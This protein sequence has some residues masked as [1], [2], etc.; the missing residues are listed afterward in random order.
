[1][2]VEMLRPADQ[3]VPRD[4]SIVIQLEA[5]VRLAAPGLQRGTIRIRQRE[6]RAF[7]NWWQPAPEQHLA[8]QIEFLGR[9]VTGIDM[10]CLTQRGE[11]RFVQIE[12]AG[13][14]HLGIRR[15]PQPGQI[16]A[17]P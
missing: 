9:L 1:M 3:I 12:P 14:A 13:L 2:G 11:P 4:R 7:I 15:Q 16:V 6:R 10:P 17:Y 5:P 8:P